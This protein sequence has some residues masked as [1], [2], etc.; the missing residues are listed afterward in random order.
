MVDVSGKGR[1]GDSGSGIWRGDVR[2]W[3]MWWWRIF[4]G[5]QATMTAVDRRLGYRSMLRA[6]KEVVHRVA[7]LLGR[8]RG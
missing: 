3:T 7:W 6:A 2:W 4:D 1:N 8:L 5:R